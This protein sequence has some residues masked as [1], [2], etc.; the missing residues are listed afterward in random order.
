MNTVWQVE[1][2]MLADRYSEAVALARQALEVFKE[3]KDRGSEAWLRYLLAEILVRRHPVAFSQAEES[4]RAASLLAH[5]LG[6]R[7][8]EAHCNLGLGQM[9]A[10]SKSTCMAQSHI[11]TAAALYRTMHM[12]YWIDKSAMLLTAIS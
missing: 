12:S 6:M 10:R 8:L 7:P 11:G 1:T 9:H 3:N 4:Y 2:Y 5:E